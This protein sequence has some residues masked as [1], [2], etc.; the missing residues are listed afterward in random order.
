[1][2]TVSIDY[3][4]ID[5]CRQSRK[6]DSA[7]RRIRRNIRGFT[8]AMMSA[9][10]LIIVAVAFVMA[11]AVVVVCLLSS[12][13]LEVKSIEVT[14]LKRVARQDLLATMDLW[15]GDNI[16]A[17][18]LE[19]IARQ[20]L[21]HPWIRDMDVQRELPHKIKM[22][23]VE[24]TPVALVHLD[25]FYYVDDQ[26]VLFARATAED[27]LDFP[28]ITGLDTKNT[29]EASPG[30]RRMLEKAVGVITFFRH[31]KN[32]LP[33]SISEVHMD[34]VLG[35]TLVL[36]GNRT[37]ILLGSENVLEKIDRLHMV[38]QVLKREGRRHAASLID[39]D[40]PDRVVVR[41]RM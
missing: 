15:P 33:S 14:G 24:R 37:P 19:D 6:V 41:F 10:Y 28:V 1:M 27:G 5:R 32:M 38:L 16:L 12:P 18:N 35:L 17:R 7:Q 39:L 26:G 30:S 29:I 3:S 11:G 20:G 9:F 34:P 2:N 8:R 36:E 23:V 13:A 4:L 21:A 22:H 31:N 25:Q 40:Y